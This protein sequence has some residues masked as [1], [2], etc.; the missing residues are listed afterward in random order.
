[1]LG[2]LAV[3]AQIHQQNIGPSEA[4]DALAGGQRQALFR[5]IVLMQAD[6]HVGRHHHVHHFR[7]RQFQIAHQLD[8]FVHR[9]HLQPRIEALLLADGGDGV[10]LVVM[11]GKNQG[12]VGQFQQPVEDRIVLRRALPFWKSVRPVPRIRSVSPVKTRSP[13]R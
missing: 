11:R 6:M 1:M 8:I 4:V 5:E 10:A 2:A 9:T 13:I 7:I 3:F 12:L